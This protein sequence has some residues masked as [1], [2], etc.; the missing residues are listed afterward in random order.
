MMHNTY[1]QREIEKINNQ[2]NNLSHEPL[3]IRKQSRADY[4]EIMRDNP[5][6]VVEGIGDMLRGDY[7][8]G[9]YIICKNIIANPRMNRIAA[10]SAMIGSLKWQ[11]S[12]LDCRKA[13]LSLNKDEQDTINAKIQTLIDEQ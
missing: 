10:L 12:A 8:E 4:A 2:M 11:C 1:E 13:Y 6:L 7:D 9:A 5:D 3:H